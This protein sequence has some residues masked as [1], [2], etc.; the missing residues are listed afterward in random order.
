MIMKN[1][2]ELISVGESLVDFISDEVT[3]RV[4]DADLYRIFPGGQVTNLAANTARLGKRV[5]LATCLGTDGFGR[6]VVEDVQ[7]KGV[8]MSFVQQTDDQPTTVSV[9]S[10]SPSL[11]DFII[12]RG[13]DTQLRYSE[14]LE[15]AVRTCKIM[16]TSAFALSREP[17]RSTILRLLA[18][19]REAGTMVTLDP[20]YHP[21]VWPDVPNFI[22]MLRFAYQ[23]VTLT[24]PSLDDCH[25]LLG[26]GK[27]PEE[28]AQIF[29][30][31]GASIVIITMGKDGVYFSGE[32]KNCR[33]VRAE[34]IKVNDVTGA[35]DAFWSGVIT[36]ILN[37]CEILD[38]VRAG[39][40]IAENKLK[41]FGPIVDMPSWK[42]IIEDSKLIQ[43]ENC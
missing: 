36:G 37:G 34:D 40:V 10:K 25:R 32:G 20:N 5:A 12:I 26:T 35:G 23:Y 21:N 27:T 41:Y 4:W 19:A 24:K 22:D 9:I 30:N 38:A 3:D 33:M 13:A 7:R 18:A 29:K 17:A 28:Y 8:D 1:F 43:F 39:Q 14:E 42:K 16:H 2:Y 31:W 15:E 11:S 6:I